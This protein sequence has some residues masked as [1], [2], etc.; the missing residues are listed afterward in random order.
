MSPLAQLWF[1]IGNGGA[2]TTIY[3]NQWDSLSFM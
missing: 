2:G 1:R 3:L